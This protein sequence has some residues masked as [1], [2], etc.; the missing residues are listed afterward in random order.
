MGSTSDTKKDGQHSSEGFVHEKTPLKSKLNKTHPGSY[1]VSMHDISVISDDMTKIINMTPTGILREEDGIKTGVINRSNS[2]SRTTLNKYQHVED[3]HNTSDTSDNNSRK[4][5]LWSE[6][7]ESVIRGWHDECIKIARVHRTGAKYHTNIFYGIGIPAS[8]FPLMLAALNDALKEEPIVTMVLLI[9]TGVL[10]TVNGFLNPGKRAEA[11]R[12]YEA[13][14]NELAV[15]ITSEL[16][17]P[18]SYRQDADVFIQRIMDR[19]NS[20][21]N[22]APPT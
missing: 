4:E 11:H 17:K 15:E 16:V 21:N 8:I 19:F 5:L 6:K 22:R 2:G 7:I 3:I 13:M 18:R 10:T 14:Y 9:S 1:N 20:L 12:N